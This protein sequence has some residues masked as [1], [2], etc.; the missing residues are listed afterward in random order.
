MPNRYATCTL[1]RRWPDGC[2]SCFGSNS[3][4]LDPSLYPSRPTGPFGASRRPQ[5]E[6]TCAPCRVGPYFGA[7]PSPTPF[8]LVICPEYICISSKN[9]LV[10]ALNAGMSKD[11]HLQ[12][13]CPPAFIILIEFTVITSRIRTYRNPIDWSF[14]GR[15][16]RPVPGFYPSFYGRNRILTV[17][18]C[19]ATQSCR[20]IT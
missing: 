12:Q 15:I 11:S 10:N 18:S 2:I 13:A 5:P 1:F 20:F 7:S 9:L 14:Y 6:S 8:E 17:R 19:F 4:W 3:Q 16:S